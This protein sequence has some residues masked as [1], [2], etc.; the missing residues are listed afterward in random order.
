MDKF[1]IL[2][3]TIFSWRIKKTVLK[4]SFEKQ[5]IYSAAKTPYFL[6]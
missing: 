3:L 2:V 1:Y 6:F 4:L 5:I